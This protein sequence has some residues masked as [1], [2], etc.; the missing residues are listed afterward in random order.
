[1]NYDRE[2]AVGPTDRFHRVMV[3]PLDPVG[4]VYADTARGGVLSGA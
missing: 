3:A 2:D 4:P 1:M